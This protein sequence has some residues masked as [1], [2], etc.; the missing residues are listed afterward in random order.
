MNDSLVAGAH[1]V[2]STS[3]VTHSCSSVRINC[4]VMPGTVPKLCP[5]YTVAW[6]HI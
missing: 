6:L 1:F 2:D 4:T 3:L 5:Q